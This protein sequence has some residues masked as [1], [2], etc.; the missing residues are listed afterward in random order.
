MTE[1][2]NFAAS[3]SPQCRSR[4]EGKI[5]QALGLKISRVEPICF[6]TKFQNNKI[7]SLVWTR[8]SV[9]HTVALPLQNFWGGCVALFLLPV[10]YEIGVG[11]K[12]HQASEF[13]FHKGCQF[14]KRGVS[15]SE[16]PRT[17]HSQV[18]VCF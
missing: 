13:I 14:S 8:I 2:I 18:R 4:F 1:V 12:R 10:N 11:T 6:T 3:E 7:L 16:G 15:G 9:V 5:L 17:S